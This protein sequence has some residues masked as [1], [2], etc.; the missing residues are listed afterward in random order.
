MAATAIKGSATT[1]RA[2]RLQTRDGK[3]I[4]PRTVNVEDAINA[5]LVFAGTPDDVWDQLKGE[6]VAPATGDIT[7]QTL[8]RRG[9]NC[10][11]LWIKIV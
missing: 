2:T 10:Q 6:I 7:K 3:P 5:G 9:S 1:A 8:A 4:N 11:D